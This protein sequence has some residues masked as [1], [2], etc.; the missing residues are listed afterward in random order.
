[1]G[2]ECPLLPQ[3][4]VR[5]TMTTIAHNYDFR[6]FCELDGLEVEGERISPPRP[7]TW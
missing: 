5:I 2:T 4:E 7:L 3:E 1:M 6:Y